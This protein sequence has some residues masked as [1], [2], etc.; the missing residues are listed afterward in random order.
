M[1]GVTPPAGQHHVQPTHSRLSHPSHALSIKTSC[2]GAIGCCR[3]PGLTRLDSPAA[4]RQCWL[5]GAGRGG[6]GPEVAR[7]HLPLQQREPWGAQATWAPE[8]AVRRP[9][10]QGCEAEEQ[11]PEQVLTLNIHTQNLILWLSFDN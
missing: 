9:G 3:L 5:P 8:A 1:L 2:L 11:K 10:A 6:Q 4:E 7:Q